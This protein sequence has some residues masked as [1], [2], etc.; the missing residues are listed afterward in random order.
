MK[1]KTLFSLVFGGLFATTALA[2]EI[3]QC[4]LES[5]ALKRPVKYRVY[6]PTGYEDSQDAFPVLYLLHGMGGNETNWS[7]P[8]NG[9]MQAICDEFF[10][11]RPETKRIVVM[12]DAQSCWYRDSADDSCK[13]ETFF[14]DELIPQ[15]EKDYRCKTTK[16]DR[17]IAGLSMGGYGSALYALRRPDMFESCVPM[18]AAIRTK[19]QVEKHSFKEFLTR[20]KSRDDMTAEEERFDD[21]YFANDPHTLVQKLEDPK[22]V[23]S[24]L[25]CGDDDDLLLGNMAFL[26]E[27]RAKGVPCELRVRDGGHVWKYWRE[28]LPICLEFISR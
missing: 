11:N 14:F 16:K 15:I 12:P 23:R 7:D 20:Y 9:N 19:E 13:Y 4:E 1:L 27:A 22:G 18:S 25:D 21:Y 28:S 2:S 6:L 26:K 17:A 3:K 8:K 24:L 10:A 5:A